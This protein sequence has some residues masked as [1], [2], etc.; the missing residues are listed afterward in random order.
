MAQKKPFVAKYGLEVGSNIVFSNNN[1]LHANNTINSYT[2]TSDM[3]ART[4][5]QSAFEG[6]NTS[7]QFGSAS[8]IPVITVG[9]DGRITNISNTTV[10]GVTVLDYV[11][12]NN[13]IR[14]ETADGSEFTA[15]IDQLEWDNYMTVA[16]AQ[17]LIVSVVANTLSTANASL[18]FDNRMLVANTRALYATL[19]GNTFSTAN[20]SA[21]ESSLN[22]SIDTKMSVAN[23]RALYTT[24]QGNTLSTANAT[25]SFN[26][27]MTVANTRLLYTTLQGNTLSTAN[28]TTSFND[29]MT[30][31]NT[32][33]LYTTLL[34]NTLSTANATVRFNNHMQVAN[35]RLLY[36]TLQG[37]T[38]STANATTQFNDRMQVANTRALYTT[39]QGNTLSTANATTLFNDRMQVANAT[40]L[41]NDRMQVANTQALANARLGATSSVTLTGDVTGSGSFS[42]NAVSITTQLE[43]DVST[44]RLSVNN[45]IQFATG[46]EDLTHSEGKLWYHDEYKTLTMHSDISDA[47]LQL[48]LE[49]WV[50]VY[51]NSGS[52]ITNGTPCRPTGVNG[53]QQT[54]APADATSPSKARVLGVATHDIPNATSGFLTVRG[55]VSGVNTEGLTPGGPVWL[56]ANGSLT[57]T[58]PTYPYYPTQ[59]GGCIVANTTAGYLYVS[60]T[61]LTQSQARVVGNQHI[62]GNLTIDGDLI[63]TGTQTTSTQNNLQV[64]NNFIYLNGGDNIGAQGTTFSGT[65]LDDA[66]F[67]DYYE[68]LFP[69]TYYVRIDG[70]GT[71]TAGVDTFQWSLD[72]F[73]TFEANTVDIT[74]GDQPLVDH[75]KIRF[76]ATTGHTLNDTWSGTANPVNIDTGWA[77]NRNTGNTGIGHSHLGVFYDVSDNNFKFFDRYDP[78]FTGNVDVGHAT[79]HYADVQANNFI[80][81]LDGNVTGD[82][83]G[84]A[85]SATALETARDIALSG[86]VTGSASFNGTSNITITADIASSGTPTGTFGSGSLVPVITVGADGR[87]T[88]ISNTSVAGVS[89]FAYTAANTTFKIDTADGSNFTATIDVQTS[90]DAFADNDTDL[91]TA[92]AINDRILELLPRIYDVANTQVFP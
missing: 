70:V 79:F 53:E 89:A 80:G 11:S 5:V 52:T 78:E 18:G 63:I 65:G 46:Q 92:A 44:A 32:R 6:S 91:L 86:D 59:V 24:L 17:S 15:T 36:T 27:R 62:G 87:I 20:A 16:N 50:R 28:A 10:A 88:N 81:N 21:L 43:D 90:S 42:S 47:S 35:T 54:V 56:A 39:L 85:A 51:N 60:P 76:N 30:V 74:G 9:E 75:I 77:S 31:A 83:T 25:A 19:V 13:T 48:G 33:A 40:I 73:S 66:T 34:A 26:D 8:E 41:F 2:I 1:I 84:V 12:S 38:L 71:G 68:G 82:L 29:R 61:Y 58:A 22:S 49:Q 3:L 7:Q 64:G 14:I 57:T 37:N 67:V 72:N 23:T 4:G 55:L 69:Q 45:Y